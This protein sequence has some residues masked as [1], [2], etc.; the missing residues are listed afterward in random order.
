MPE[1]TIGQTS[2]LLGIPKDTLRYYNK[3]KLVC[4]KRSAS[5]YRLYTETNLVEL[6]CVYVMKYAG[7]SL[8]EIDVFFKGRN[9]LDENELKC[10]VLEMLNAKKMEIAIRITHLSKLEA[11]MKSSIKTIRD[12][13]PSDAATADRL[14]EDIFADITTDKT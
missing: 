1:Y 10:S 4:P 8:G 13:R 2:E 7:F 14:I 3:L 5:G 11:L 9:R 6:K 12:K